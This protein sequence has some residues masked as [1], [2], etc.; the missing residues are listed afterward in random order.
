MD[1]KDGIDNS[2]DINFP[3]ATSGIFEFDLKPPKTVYVGDLV[4]ASGASSASSLYN[5]KV[6]KTTD[7]DN[8]IGYFVERKVHA[9]KAEIVLRAAFS[10]KNKI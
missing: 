6:M 3:I 7:E 8:S 1:D 10:S 4:G 9:L 5:Q 2:S